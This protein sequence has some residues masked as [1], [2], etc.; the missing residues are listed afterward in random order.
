M[1]NLNIE[2]IPNENNVIFDNNTVIVDTFKQSKCEI[3]II[4]DD[5]IDNV[6]YTIVNENS[7]FDV[8][9]KWNI[10]EIFFKKNSLPYQREGYFYIEHNLSKDVSIKITVKQSGDSKVCKLKSITIDGENIDVITDNEIEQK[11]QQPFLEQQIVNDNIFLLTEILEKDG[12]NITKYKKMDIIFEP[13]PNETE[14]VAECIFDLSGGCKKMSIK[15][16]KKYFVKRNNVDKTIADSFNEIKEEDVNNII[17]AYKQ[18]YYTYNIKKFEKLQDN[19]YTVISIDDVIK[20]NIEQKIQEIKD[21]E[22]YTQYI[23]DNSQFNNEYILKLAEKDATDY[24]L[25]NL[26][27]N[28]EFEYTT[29][30]KKYYNN[31]YEVSITINNQ[32]N[33]G[34][35]YQLTNLQKQE[36][37]VYQTFYDDAFNFEIDKNVFRIHNYGRLYL[38]DYACFYVVTLAHIEDYDVTYDLY[39]TYSEL[40]EDVGYSFYLKNKSLKSFKPLSIVENIKFPYVASTKAIQ[41][42]KRTN[43]EINVQIDD[44]DWISYSVK[45]NVVY[46]TSEDNINNNYREATCNCY[47]GNALLKTCIIEQQPFTDYKIEVENSNYI[48]K[49]NEDIINIPLRVFG[50]SKDIIIESNPSLDVSIEKISTTSFYDLYTLQIIP[51]HNMDIDFKELYILIYHFD[52]RNIYN[53]LT[54]TQGFN[55]ENINEYIICENKISF[56]KNELIKN[57]SYQTYPYINSKIKCYSNANWVKCVVKTDN[58]IDI[59]VLP[60]NKSRQCNLFI[61]NNDFP[62][63]KKKIEIKQL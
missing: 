14:Q 35:S 55:G 42:L 49:H 23:I 25:Q 20:Y 47:V 36:T 16:I 37:I 50:G 6:S 21:D 38:E 54:I 53:K 17:D 19:D 18:I 27:E 52:D 63:F 34:Y 10:I 33:S 43:N 28:G 57:I 24:V 41:I 31:G 40:T 11:S 2:F 8:V 13:Y 15:N 61:V 1:Y 12:E 58:S 46:L 29:S 9:K 22:K 51:Q 62:L 32:S 59:K 39:I 4:V 7:W 3:K 5:D 48:I 26:K 45:N 44:C 30:L 56:G 60:T